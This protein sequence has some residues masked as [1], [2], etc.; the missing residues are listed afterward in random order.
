M[1]KQVGDFKQSEFK[2]FILVILVL[3]FCFSFRNW[4]SRTFD[5]GIGISNLI[6]TTILVAIAML[7]HR[8]AHKYMAKRYESNIQFVTWKTALFVAILL[9]FLTNGWFVF[10]AI[11]ALVVT[12]P[13]FH[14]PRHRRSHVGPLEKAKIVI[15]GPVINLVLGIIAASIAFSTG[16]Y[17]WSKFMYINLW[18]AGVNLFPFFRTIGAVILSGLHIAEPELIKGT[19][20][21]IARRLRRIFY[22]R[23]GMT[24]Y[25]EG[26]MI[27]HGSRAMWA[28]FFSFFLLLL[29]FLYTL[30]MAI[31]S[32]VLAFILS[33][34]IYMFWQWT[35]EPWNK[36]HTKNSNPV[37]EKRK[38]RVDKRFR[39]VQKK[40]YLFD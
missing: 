19:T 16:S 33:W 22:I 17:I 7:F 9:C 29:I 31:T 40:S 28:F 38:G 30:K 12:Y 32:A 13:R 24:P 26:E 18:I 20:Y 2:D 35:M 27:F 10:T 4:G 36:F 5:F 6:L 14:R 11:W 21:S 23:P 37:Y 34:L 1:K 39:K 8:A 15:S 3:G 25:M